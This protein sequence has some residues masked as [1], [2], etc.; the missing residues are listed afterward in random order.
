M[1]EVI[2]FSLENCEKC[3]QIKD[4]IKERKDI[5]IVTYPHFFDNWTEDQIKEAK[6]YDVFDDLQITAPVLWVDKKK[7][8]GYLRIRKF[9]QDNKYI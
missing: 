6:K 7:F 8:V 1:P 3:L 2:L 5:K 9:L 4:L